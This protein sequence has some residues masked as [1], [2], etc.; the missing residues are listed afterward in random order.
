MFLFFCFALMCITY[1]PLLE[2][3]DRKHRHFV[4]FTRLLPGI[5]TYILGLVLA[6]DIDV[7]ETPILLSRVLQREVSK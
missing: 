6:G 4:L 1:F 7:N 5:D 2:L 3:K